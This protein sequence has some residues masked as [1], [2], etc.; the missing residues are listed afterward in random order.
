M[1]QNIIIVEKSYTL[2]TMKINK[3]LILSA[4]LGTRMGNIGEVLPKV[5]WPV[6][7]KPILEL[8]IRYARSI[9]AKR[10][11]INTHHGSEI[12][13]G[14]I[15]NSDFTDVHVL[16][17]PEL[18]GIGG[19]IHR[20]KEISQEDDNLLVINGDQFYF[21]DKNSFANG[22]ELIR[23]NNVVLFAIKVNKNQGYNQLIDN[24]GF[25]VNIKTQ[26]IVPQEY[27][28]YSGV[29]V[30]NLKKLNFVAGKSDFFQTVAKYEDGKVKIVEPHGFEYW[31]FG[32]TERYFSSM[33]RVLADHDQPRNKNS[34]FNELCDS[35]GIFKG[36][37][38]KQFRSS[39]IINLSRYAC[40]TGLDVRAI[41]IDSNGPQTIFE[42]GIYYKKYFNSI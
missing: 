11:Y 30:V 5:M 7:G 1:I 19:T 35:S 21:P 25:L 8:Q 37:D 20:I 10:I 42:S 12:I 24:D 15:K 6:F 41:V 23:E 18:L 40:K 32:T 34:G 27:N 9:G 13:H 16:Y 33:F 36:L 17:E 29:C 28:T 14:Y 38:C 2:I 39:S 22:L 26:A 31:D 4:G 3:C